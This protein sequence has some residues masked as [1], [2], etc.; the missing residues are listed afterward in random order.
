MLLSKNIL[1]NLVRASRSFSSSSTS[2]A[3][4][5]CALYPDPVQGYPPQYAR[6]DIPHIKGYA[7]GQTA[8]TP[9]S[10]DFQPG[11][12]LGCVSGGLGLRKFLESNGHEFV[13]TSDKDGENSE[14]EKHLPSADIVISQP[15]YP[16]Y[17][18]PERISKAKKLKNGSNR[19]HWFRSCQFGSCLCSENV[20]N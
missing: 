7:D 8:P 20:C 1:S 16:A 2:S 6:D 9:S 3:K 13:V 15:F 4:V 5:L 14:F 10:I 11:E 19:W 12:L 18:T 17:L